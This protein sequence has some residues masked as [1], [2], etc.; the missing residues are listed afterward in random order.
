MKLLS[1]DELKPEKG[2]TYSKT[3]LWRLEKEARF[4]RRVSL[5]GNPNGRSAWLESE[6]DE[7]IKDRI[8]QRDAKAGAHASAA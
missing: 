8:A 5:T 6:I 3:Q 2:I 1:Y 7:W 4:P